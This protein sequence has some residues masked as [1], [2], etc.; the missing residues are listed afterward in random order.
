MDP[1]SPDNPGWADKL[2]H[3][4]VIAL[5]MLNLGGEARFVDTEHIAVEANRIAP[6]RFS[7]V[8]YPDQINIHNIKTCLWKSKSV[9][10]G[11]LVLG[12]DKRGWMLTKKGAE[13]AMK[14]ASQLP[15]TIPAISRQDDKSDKWKSVERARL[16]NSDAFKKFSDRGDEAVTK[17]EVE[18]FFRINDYV[19]GDVRE[20]KIVRLLNVFGD[21]PDLGNAVKALA[22]KLQPG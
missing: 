14:L 9:A 7:W 11:Y 2:A 12:S 19:I 21:D 13:M 20:K 6:G 15:E 1:K 3:H 18:A 5:A 17:A 4:E 16:I 8:H 22:K 10:T